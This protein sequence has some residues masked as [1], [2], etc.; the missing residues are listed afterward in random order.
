MKKIGVILLTIGLLITV[1]TGFNLIT[2]EK[3]VDIGSI[4]ITANKDHGIT[5]SPLVGIGVMVVGGM[6]LLFSTKKQ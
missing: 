1:V 5:W 4:E 2:R 6:V 3:V